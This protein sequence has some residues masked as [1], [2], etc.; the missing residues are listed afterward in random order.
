MHL[1]DSHCHLDMLD[2]TRT[3]VG[4][5][6]DLAQ[7]LA[8]ARR[9]GVKHFLSIN[10]DPHQFDALQALVAPFADVSLSLGLHP[11][12]YQEAPALT[13]ADLLEKARHEQVVA[14][15]ETGLDYHYDQ[16]YQAQQRASFAEHLEVA[17]A[18]NKPVIVHTR[19]AAE[20]TLALLRPFCQRGG[21]GVIHCFTEDLAFAREVIAMGL[22]ISFSGIVTFH[23]AKA[24]RE[25]A[26]VVPLDRVLVETDAPYLAPVPFRG[27][28]NEPGYVREVASCLAELRGL[29]PE[30]VA[31]QTTEN[32]FRLF[33]CARPVFTSESELSG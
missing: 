18:V 15:G 5:D 33:Q 30:L 17:L 13:S 28:Q 25:V 9:R 2:L 20:D 31:Q 16:S 24:L 19:D 14:I 8:A 22:Y 1:V 27:Q 32:F 11:L 4:A 6:A 3:S 23:S 12:H 7:V 26:R 29:S 21:Q 10:V